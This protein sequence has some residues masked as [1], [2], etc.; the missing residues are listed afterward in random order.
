MRGY[1]IDFILN[2]ERF[3]DYIGLFLTNTFNKNNNIMEKW[4]KSTNSIC[5]FLMSKHKWYNWRKK[6]KIGGC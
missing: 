3:W 5:P 4:W 6:F 1:F 2:D